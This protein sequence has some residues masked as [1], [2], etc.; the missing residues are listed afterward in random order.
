MLRRRGIP[1]LSHLGV[2]D[3]APLAPHAWVSVN[4]HV[5]VGGPVDHAIE[6]AAFR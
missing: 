1:A 6:L 4:G 3:A 2:A 5:V